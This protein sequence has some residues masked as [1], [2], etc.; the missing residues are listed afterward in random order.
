MSEQIGAV[1]FALDGVLIDAQPVWRG[2]RE[3]L[4]RERGGTWHEQAEAVMADTSATEWS[5]YMHEQL[6]LPEAP[7]EITEEVVRRM[8]LE[9]RA[10]LPFLP[11]AIEAVV[12][13]GKQYRLAVASSAD[14]SL[15][16]L[17][18]GRGGIAGMFA[19][20]VSSSEVAHG[21]PA[22]DLF[23]E[24]ARRLDLSP[25][26]CVAVQSSASGIRAA[27]TAGMRVLAFSNTQP[28]P[29]DDVLQ[30]LDELT[31]DSIG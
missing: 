25:E 7:A 14:R 20:T 22:P 3:T 28:P 4:V 11:G 17:V 8:Y 24:T 16:D 1:V 5:T 21:P 9:Y 19:A 12:R 26:R 23:L 13:L 15:I 27:D 10:R 18:L 2:V 29:A 31:L 30:S 6:G